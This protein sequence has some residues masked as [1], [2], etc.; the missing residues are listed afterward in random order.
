MDISKNSSPYSPPLTH[1]VD[2]FRYWCFASPDSVAFHFILDQDDEPVS[3][4][5]RQLDERIRAVAAKLNSKVARGQRAILMYQSTL[6]FVIAFFACHYAGIIAV[7]AY[8]PRRNRRMGRINAIAEDC[9]A[10]IALTAGEV[11]R[12]KE[13]MIEDCDALRNIPWVATEEIPLEMAGDWVY[14]DL[15]RDE[16]GLLQY[17]S[18]STGSPKG[19][20]LTHA[21]IMANLA[22]ISE[23]FEL[24]RS[25][26]G[27][28][29][30][31]PYHDMG[32]IGGLLVSCYW[33]GMSVA[34]T[35]IQFL[36]KPIRWLRAISKFRGNVAGGPNFAYS[37]CVNRIDEADCE[38]LDLSSWRVAFNGA[39]PIRSE[40]LDAFTK[41]F[42]PYGFEHKNHYPCYG[43]AETTLLVTGSNIDQPPIYKSVSRQH[44]A[45]HRVVSSKPNQA[46]SRI[47][48]GC[49]HP[50]EG[51]KIIIVH[52][53]ARR[54]LPADQIGEIWVK[55]DSVG[56]GY[57]NKPEETEKT[58]RGTL[59]DGV[60]GEYFLRTGDLGFMDGNELYVTGR[61]KDMIVIRGVNRY[62]QDIEATVERV[63][64]RLQDAGAAAFA[65]DSWERERLLVVCEVDRQRVETDWNQI[66]DQIRS[67]VT[68]EHDLAPDG[69]ILV[70]AGSVP[71]TSSGKVQRRA[72]R[73]DYLENRLLVV[74]KWLSWE[75]S[76]SH[77]WIPEVDQEQQPIDDQ[78]LGIVIDHVRQVAKERAKSINEDTNIVI[79]LGLDS[80]ERL[81]IANSLED[82]FGGRFPDDVLQEIETIREICTAIKAHIGDRPVAIISKNE[83]AKEKKLAIK[84]PIPSSYY[85]LDQMPEFIRV[86]QLR[87]VFESTGIRNPFF[88]L[89]EGVI[90][91]TTRI[92]GREL[93]SFS[94]YNYINMSGNPEV[95]AAAKSAI[96]QF[97]T[98]SSASRLVS[99]E[100]TVH[101]QL[102]RELAQFLGVED[103]VT[104]AGGHAT[105][106]STIGHLVGAGD[107]ILHD[108]LA[109]N[110][111]IQGAALSGARRRSFLHNDWRNLDEV[112]SEIRHEY[113]RVLVAIE[114]LYSMDGDSP[115]LAR[116]VEIKKKH[117]VWLFVDEA[118]SIGTLGPTGRGIGEIYGV[119][120]TDVEVWMG[121]LSKSMG[122]VG[123]FIGGKRS[124][125]EYLRY[126]NPGFVF[127]AALAPVNAA[128][129]LASLRILKREPERVRQLA[130]N[131]RLFLELAR[132]AGLNTGMSK[133]SPIIPIITGNSLQALQLSQA[134]YFRGFN[135]QPILHPAVEEEKAR[136]RFFITSAHSS[137]QIRAAVSALIEEY[138]KI[139]PQKFDVECSTR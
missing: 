123:G 78:L 2:R 30:L 25:S 62:P 34:M 57:W 94:S 40:T 74:A 102:E 14:P 42:E 108:A 75:K 134:L 33:G 126:T 54:Q 38:G 76:A 55:S 79:D 23:A 5:Y 100:K 56:Q 89:H 124:L 77:D 133:D 60:E 85:E 122:S 118:H 93:I 128:A 19:V 35:P 109:H 132:E 105:N 72:C 135:V 15:D 107:L 32:L 16:V 36:T 26:V 73:D 45:E 63:S 101:K 28:T 22:Y 64:D 17:T 21:N 95:T 106:E 88:S 84:G 67:A 69:I 86:Q 117:K 110:S 92:D 80:L 131:S 27:V 98:S 130:E 11:I 71:K 13:G 41:K 68:E 58:F 137:D 1:L 7:P 136:L 125:I 18:G 31:P 50:V 44:L 20:V 70:R 65:I 121:T 24:D 51:E 115:D 111:I 129:A 61:L 90:S 83:S 119:D 29:W 37:L 47:L 10:A 8:P 6:D 12:R 87:S 81:Q 53:E 4:T 9:Q 112:L 46:D 52:P 91:D 99:G 103:V 48:V 59:V 39:E 96:D 138:A 113:R 127:A 139:A 49:G 3:L 120:R 116:F 66:I 43:M 104:M 82:T 97:G 114:G